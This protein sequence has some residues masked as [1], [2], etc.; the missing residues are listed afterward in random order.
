MGKGH[1]HFFQLPVPGR[2]WQLSQSRPEVTG[3]VQ[4]SRRAAAGPRA[5]RGRP[6]VC[7]GGV[8]SVEGIATI[9]S[10]R[11]AC[12]CRPSPGHLGLQRPSVSGDSN[13][14]SACCPKAPTL[15]T[16]SR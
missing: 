12:A 13:R 6:A 7:G 2:P 15:C 16:F 9:S 10:G 11:R 1:P 8:Q 3:H 4:R 14:P 5:G